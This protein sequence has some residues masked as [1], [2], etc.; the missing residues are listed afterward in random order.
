M[1]EMIITFFLQHSFGDDILKGSIMVANS[2]L[3][4]TK[5]K[6]NPFYITWKIMRENFKWKKNLKKKVKLEMT[7]S[8]E[9]ESRINM[10][11]RIL[12]QIGTL[13]QIMVFSYIS[14]NF[15]SISQ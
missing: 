8:S 12:E 7:F 5:K 4:Y 10:M 13:G 2:K 14:E 9:S 11:N 1:S 15:L 6:N 3:M